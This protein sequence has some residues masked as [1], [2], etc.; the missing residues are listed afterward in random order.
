MMAMDLNI[1]II[2]V[3]VKNMCDRDEHQPR[4]SIKMSNITVQNWDNYIQPVLNANKKHL[5]LKQHMLISPEY[6]NQPDKCIAIISGKSRKKLTKVLK[7]FY[8]QNII[9]QETQ[10][11]HTTK[12]EGQQYNR[13]SRK[14]NNA[15]IT[16]CKTLNQ[17]RQCEQ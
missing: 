13:I 11:I 7:P 5:K 10:I 15:V 16:G 1:T 9:G 17:S 2:K 3:I 8:T 12:E 6:H 4:Y 14:R